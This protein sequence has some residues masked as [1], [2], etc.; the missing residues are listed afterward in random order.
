MWCMTAWH[1]MAPL[2]FST[3]IGPFCVASK[4]HIT[5]LCSLNICC[6]RHSNLSHLDSLLSS[7]PLGARKMV[8]TDGLFS[9]DGDFA[10]L[11]VIPMNSL[12]DRSW[13]DHLV[14]FYADSHIL[15]LQ[16]AWRMEHVNA[17]SLGIRFNNCQWCSSKLLSFSIKL[18]FYEV[19]F[20]CFSSKSSPR[21]ASEFAKFVVLTR[22]ICQRENSNEFW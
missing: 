20:C 5:V 14:L 22:R 19:L 6:F 7:C 18:T 16:P 4:Y 8:V 9:M 3:I 2:E 13:L 17:V 10:D 21:K 1:C 12:F 11:Q 15:P